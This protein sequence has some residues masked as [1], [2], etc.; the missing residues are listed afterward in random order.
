MSL[1]VNFRDIGESINGRA[2]IHLLKTGVVY[3]SARPAGDSLPL[4]HDRYGINTIIDL[5]TDTERSQH[6]A[7][8]HGEGSI[9][10]K[11]VDFNGRP[12][13]TALMKQL[14]YWQTLQLLGYY[15]LGY[16]R[17]AISILGEHVL[18]PRGLIGLAQDSLAHCTAEVKAVFNI[19]T[20]D[21][22]PYL[23]HCTQGK[24][25][26]GLVFLLLLMLLDIPVNVIHQDY[27]AS[28]KELNGEREQRLK[29]I[30]SI[31]L[32]D[33]FADCAEGWT[34]AVYEHIDT[35]YGGIRE[36][37]RHCNIPDEQQE[38]VIEQLRA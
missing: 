19:L 32:P 38:A 5:R 21:A 18:A 6:D 24:D 22:A 11:I 2:G 20:S 12:Y 26:T 1:P 33:S 3:R 23:I 8:P 28:Q 25:R 29:E 4:L 35:T 37:L 13:T 36:Y 31:G 17:E 27:M 16:R 9:A 10:S 15:A 30:Q 34:K 14:T 7:V